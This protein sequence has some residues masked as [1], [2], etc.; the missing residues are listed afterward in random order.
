[1]D[2]NTTKKVL[3]VTLGKHHVNPWW[4]EHINTDCSNCLVEYIR[5]SFK[6]K[7]SMEI[8]TVEFP[9]LFIQIIS[10][11]ISWHKKYDYIFTFECDLM[12]FFISAIQSLLPTK[13]KPRHVILQFIMREKEKTLKSNLKYFI[14]KALF[15]SLH[16]VVCSST[17]ET[18]YY[19]D[20]FN[21]PH[22]KAVFVPFHTAPEAL[23]VETRDEAYIFS[24]GKS[25]RD[26]NTLIKSLDNIEQHSVIIGYGSTK[27]YKRITIHQKLPWE[28]FLD[29]MARSRIVVVP[30]ED[31]KISTGQTIILYAMALGKPVVTTKTS[32][33]IDYIESGKTGILVPPNNSQELQRQILI[34][35]NDDEFRKKIGDASRQAV[36][37]KYLPKHYAYNIYKKIIL[38]DLSKA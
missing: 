13:R 17:T 33:T 10:S 18:E 7:Q 1:M 2:N 16:K 38:S 35:L 34:L 11:Y 9:M 28:Q 4:W 31:R 25:F 26:Y 36:L 30:L 8:R 29:Y 5:F 6:D 21:W 20:V 22:G 37:K 23:N 27:Q 32:G 14:M 19:R 3:V 24:G 12:G 15:S